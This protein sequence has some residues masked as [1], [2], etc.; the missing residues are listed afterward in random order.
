[1]LVVP[2]DRLGCN[3]RRCR[4]VDRPGSDR[5]QGC[6]TWAATVAGSPGNRSGWGP[7]SPVSVPFRWRRLVFT[8]GDEAAGVRGAACC[9]VVAV[10]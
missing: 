7:I 5:I 6:V 8:E 4:R 10:V 3:G 2:I 1:L 9:A